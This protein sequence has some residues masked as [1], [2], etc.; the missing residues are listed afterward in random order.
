M[1]QQL[2]VWT[3]IQGLDG[4]DK[5]LLGNPGVAYIPSIL[6]G[7]EVPEALTHH[8]DTEV[9]VA[10]DRRI[11]Q[12]TKSMWNDSIKK[13]ASYPYST[14]TSFQADTGFLAMGFQMVTTDG[15]KILVAE[16][17]SRE[18]FAAV[19]NSHLAVSPGGPGSQAALPED[20]ALPVAE[21]SPSILLDG[22]ALKVWHLADFCIN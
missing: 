4:V 14:I 21:L 6:E 1:N 5:K 19:V 3:V 16:K 2:D 9:L 18:Q 22:F 12:I 15:L 11:V 13:V 7:D 8:G 20:G 10:T 17:N